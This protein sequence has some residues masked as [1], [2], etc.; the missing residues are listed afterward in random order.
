MKT[1]SKNSKNAT[2]VVALT[3]MNGYGLSGNACVA[4]K[5]GELDCPAG[6]SVVCYTGFNLVSGKC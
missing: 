2:L 3:C 5:S 4:C 6:K 1:C